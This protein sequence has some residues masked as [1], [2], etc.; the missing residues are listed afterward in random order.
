[1]RAYLRSLAC[2]LSS[3]AALLPGLSAAQKLSESWGTPVIV[4]VRDGAGGVIGVNQVARSA[5]DG[6]T[7]L[8]TPDLPIAIAPAVSKTPYDPRKDL[9]AIGA[10]AQGVSV[11]VVHPAVGA[12]SVKDLV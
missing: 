3:I 4:E 8:F 1:M 2:V 10:V 12:A 11:L 7:L 9:T 6:Y 5:A